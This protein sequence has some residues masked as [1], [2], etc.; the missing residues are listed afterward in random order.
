ME[1]R[2]KE[3]EIAGAELA[4]IWG[5]EV[6][7]PIFRNWNLSSIDIGLVGIKTDGSKSTISIGSLAEIS[8]GIFD[9]FLHGTLDSIPP[10]GLD[11][12]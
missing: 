4:S 11:P 6:M 10:L 3:E 8:F 12:V 9:C 2:S 1:V 7:N 5:S